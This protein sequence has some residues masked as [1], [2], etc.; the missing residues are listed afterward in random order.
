MSQIGNDNPYLTKQDREK[1]LA[2]VQQGIDARKQKTIADTQIHTTAAGLEDASQR[3]GRDS[4]VNDDSGLVERLLN[5]RLENDARS[6]KEH[7]QAS[8]PVP[9]TLPPAQ[10]RPGLDVNQMRQARELQAVES[11]PQRARKRRRG[12]R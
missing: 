10:G 7:G 5:E 4:T 9:L 3:S 1:H 12:R 2:L 8:V 11:Q 6:L